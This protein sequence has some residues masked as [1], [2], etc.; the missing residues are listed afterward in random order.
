MK[1]GKRTTGTVAY[2][3]TFYF[4]FFIQKIWIG[5]VFTIFFTTFDKKVRIAKFR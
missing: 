2:V 3:I 1:N 4:Y 5:R